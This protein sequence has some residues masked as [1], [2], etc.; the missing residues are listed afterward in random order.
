MCDIQVSVIVPVYNIKPYIRKNIESLLS[1]TD[2]GIEF[3]YVDDGSTDDSSVILNEYSEKDKR[4]VVIRQENAGLSAARNTGIDAAKGKWILFVDG[5]D[6]LDTEETERFLK[7]REE[8]YDIIWGGFERVK[9]NDST[10]NTNSKENIKSEAR[11][12]IEWLNDR[13]IDYTACV[14]LYKAKLIKENNIKFPVGLLHED[15]EFVPKVFTFAQNIKRTNFH[16]YRYFDRQNSI[17]TTR[18]IKRSQDLIQI[19]DNLK[20]F[21]EHINNRELDGYVNDYLASLIENAIHLAILSHFEIKEI[22]QGDKKENMIRYLLNGSRLC[23]KL[24]GHMLRM[25]LTKCYEKM[26]LLYDMLR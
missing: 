14:Y 9:E 13:T 7:E 24:A 11:S 6:W 19:A 1:L 26:Y 2:D 23:D 12:G 17:S 10:D 5:D 22:L 4:I 8:K 3:I 15:M 16:Y 21:Y 20:S 25:G 18:N